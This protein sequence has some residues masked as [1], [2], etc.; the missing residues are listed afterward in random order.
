M[1][2]KKA[3]NILYYYRNS[4]GS[5]DP[6]AFQI[7]LWEL[8]SYIILGFKESR[9]PVALPQQSYALKALECSWRLNIFQ[10]STGYVSIENID[11]FINKFTLT[12]NIHQKIMEIVTN[13]IEYYALGIMLSL[14]KTSPHLI[15]TAVYWFQFY[16]LRNG[17]L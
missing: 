6:W 4:L 9:V 13:I 14:L 8:L 15:F 7:I 2:E 1:M 5:I 16:R 10:V 3:N 17:G 11:H 12:M